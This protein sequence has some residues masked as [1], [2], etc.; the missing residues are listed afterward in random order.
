[1]SCDA[2][3][4]SWQ[5]CDAFPDG[6]LRSCVSGGNLEFGGQL[7]PRR[8]FE[9]PPKDVPVDVV[10]SVA[11]LSHKYEVQHLRRRSIL[12]IERNFSMEMDTFVPCWWGT[13]DEQG[14]WFLGLEKLLNIIVIATY[15]NALWVLPAAYYLCSE[16]TPSHTLRDASFWN[17][18]QCATVL[19]NVLA[20]KINLD[21]MDVAYEDLIGTSPCSGC[22]HREQCALTTLA[23]ARLVRSLIT[24]TK[25]AGR[26]PHTLSFWWKRSWLKKEHCKELCAPCSSAS[27]SAYES[28]RGD[29]WDKIPSAFNLPSWKELKT[30][31]E[32]NFRE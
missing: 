22:I 14:L 6:Y 26:K 5:E 32:T 11:Q 27:M 13:C 20:G 1:V 15:I 30:L 16:E 9:P 17:S 3:T 28:A 8:F 19:R 10:L 7:T 24:Q 18:S 31:R 4:R 21:V 29:Y 2:S 25:G 23:T 12:H